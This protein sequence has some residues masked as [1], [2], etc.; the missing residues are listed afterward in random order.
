MIDAIRLTQIQVMIE[1]LSPGIHH[2]G[3]PFGIGNCGV[4][5]TNNLIANSSWIHGFERNRN[6]ISEMRVTNSC[7]IGSCGVIAV[8]ISSSIN[9]TILVIY[10]VNT[11]PGLGKA[12]LVNGI[13]MIYGVMWRYT[14]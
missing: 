4:S 13:L 8:V 1:E 14:V 10:H 3:K 6:V 11:S 5:L 7:E 12:D 2:A 9:S